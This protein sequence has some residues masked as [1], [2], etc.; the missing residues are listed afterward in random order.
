MGYLFLA[1]SLFSGT[2]KGYCGKK[3]SGQVKSLK[4]S[5]YINVIRMSLCIIIG[6]L[7]ICFEN[8][9]IFIYDYKTIL[10]SMLSGVSTALFVVLW[11]FAVR[12]GVYVMLDVF[13]MLGVGITLSLCRIF[14]NEA[15]TLNQLIGLLMLILSACIMCSYNITIK[16]KF[17]LNSFLILVL[18][19]FC[20]GLSDFSQKL[21][22]SATKNVSISIFNFYTYLF[23]VLT[24]ILFYIPLKKSDKYDNDGKSKKTMLLILIMAICLFANSYFKTLAA[25]Y[26]SS[27]VLYP[28]AT[29]A[30]LILS[31]LMSSILFKEKATPKCIIGA[32]IAFISLIIINI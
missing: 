26:I 31:V 13:I 16:N 9:P 3:I 28:L 1:T 14:L 5:V 17:T 25:K 21:F 18:C 19:S 23:A 32:T 20:N 30:S 29:G 24:L 10:I 7:L 8:A 2:L 22:I 11:L 27:S 15:I 6:F 12:N 4:G